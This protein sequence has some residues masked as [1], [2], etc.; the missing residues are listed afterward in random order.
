MP[1]HLSGKE[2][3]D[4]NLGPNLPYRTLN[5]NAN[6][7]EYTEEK[8]EGEVPLPIG[9]ADGKQDYQLVTFLP[10]DPDNPKK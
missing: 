9:R 1:L 3:R 4:L 2:T 8:P 10:D 7:S 5:P 6:L